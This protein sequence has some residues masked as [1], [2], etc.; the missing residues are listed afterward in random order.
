MLRGMMGVG[1]GGAPV[2]FALYLELVPSRLR[3]VLM[4]AL[5]AFW[6]VGSM[7]EAQLLPLLCHSCWAAMPRSH[8]GASFLCRA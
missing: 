4:V 7:A 3:G 8:L 5:Q 6:S 1:L 2:S